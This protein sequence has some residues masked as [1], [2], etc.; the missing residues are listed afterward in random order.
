MNA[1]AT[2]TT[3]RAELRVVPGNRGWV[4][5]KGPG[6]PPLLHGPL[7]VAQQNHPLHL[8]VQLGAKVRGRIEPPE[9]VASLGV[10]NSLRRKPGAV[11]RPLEGPRRD[12]PAW[13]DACNIAD[14]GSFA[15]D[16]V[17]AGRWSL[18]LDKVRQDSRGQLLIGF[19]V[20]PVATLELR[21]GE[22][23]ELVIDGTKFTTSTLTGTVRIDGRPLSNAA[24]SIG[25]RRCVGSGT[26]GAER[27]MSV[28]T[29]QNGAFSTVLDPPACYQIGLPLRTKSFQGG[30]TLLAWFPA[31]VGGVI[32]H[33]FDLRTGSVRLR[34][35][36][37]DGTTPVRQRQ[38]LFASGSEGWFGQGT[39]N[40][41]GWIEL[42][43]MPSV[44]WVPRIHRR[45][46][47][48]ALAA[49]QSDQAWWQDTVELEP[50][51]VTEGV[52]SEVVRKLPAK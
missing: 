52:S 24:V 51:T 34:L 38:V 15:L 43:P 29:D 12:V 46:R 1:L 44:R 36:E 49:G 16:D 6:H 4:R 45:S 28:P 19:I 48:E 47:A 13:P 50:F 32:H 7:T 37:A 17:P 33:D 30:T 8:V 31:P 39:T 40:D 23:S 9:F 27:G 18:Y 25:A 3:G 21:D 41:D 5:A 22:T 11:L 35:V 26:T 20:A 14:D 2:D 42:P 10:T